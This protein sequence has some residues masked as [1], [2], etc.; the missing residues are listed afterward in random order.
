[1]TAYIGMLNLN[2]IAQRNGCKIESAFVK[3]D[4]KYTVV[5]K[6]D[7]AEVGRAKVTNFDEGGPECVALAD[8][9]AIFPAGS[10]SL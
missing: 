7:G 3:G 2:L 1:M 8:L 4:P 9:L 5:F 10:V 6:R